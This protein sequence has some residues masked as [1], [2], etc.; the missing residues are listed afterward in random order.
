MELTPDVIK[1]CV[2]A[3]RQSSGVVGVIIPEVSFGIGFWAQCKA[4]ERSFYNGFEPIEAARFISRQTYSAI[5]GFDS[6]LVA[7]EDWDLSNR[8]KQKGNLA[9]ISSAIRHN[10]GHIKLTDSL[11]KKYY[12]AQHARE[13]LAKNPQS[14]ML[15]AAGPLARYKLFLSQPFKLLHNPVVGI[16]MLLMKTAEFSMMIGAYTSNQGVRKCLPSNRSSQ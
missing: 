16:G 11:R 6:T 10:E 15:S 8:L 12:Y 7:G 9:R 3:M 5:G 14:K 4:L 13:Y 1:D 2:A